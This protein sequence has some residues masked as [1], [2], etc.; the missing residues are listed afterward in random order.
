MKKNVRLSLAGLSAFIIFPGSLQAALEYRESEVYDSRTNLVWKHFDTGD[1][2]VSHGYKVATIE[3]LAGLF[4]SYAPLDSGGELPGYAPDVGGVASYT[5]RE[6]GRE[7]S[8]SWRSSY[9]WDNF[10]PPSLLDGLQPSVEFGDG[11][12]APGTDALLT[13]VADGENY[14]PVLLRSVYYGDQYGLIWGDEEGVIGVD[15]SYFQPAS[16]FDNY[17]QRYAYGC[18]WGQGSPYVDDAGGLIT[19]GVLMV[20][21]VPEPDGASLFLFGGALLVA[22]SIKKSM[23]SRDDGSFLGTR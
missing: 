5:V 6:D 23:R 16:F 14:V 17:C 11:M 12:F 7:F 15:E 2:G 19:Q 22:G 13:L 8:V 18:E 9:Y 3:Q 20:S 4:L 21:S 10:A 1:V